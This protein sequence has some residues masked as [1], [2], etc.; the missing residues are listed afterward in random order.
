LT[1]QHP[2]EFASAGMFGSGVINGEN[3]PSPVLA[4]DIQAAKRM[5]QQQ[6]LDI[7][8]KLIPRTN[9]FSLLVVSVAEQ[10][11]WIGDRFAGKKVA[12]N[13]GEFLSLQASA[14]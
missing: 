10:L 12:A 2:D 3:E 5:Y 7:R 4:N 8:F 1:F 14:R 9:H 11:E 13:R 6:D